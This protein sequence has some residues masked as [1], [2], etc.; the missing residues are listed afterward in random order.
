MLISSGGGGGAVSYSDDIFS[1][2]VYKG[3]GTSLS[4]DNG[5][6]L[7]TY[8]GLVWIKMRDS[9]YQHF[10]CDTRDP[11]VGLSTNNNSAQVSYQTALTSFMSSGF[12][13][14]SSVLVNAA[15]SYI[16]WTFRNANSFFKQLE[17]THMSGTN[18]SINL[19]ALG[20]VGMVAVK[21]TNIVGDWVVW[22]RGATAGNNL[23]LNSNS[24][25]S[26]TNAWLSVV[27]TTATLSSS[28]PSAT[29]VI[30][31]WA[32]DTTSQGN[33]QCG[34]V[35]HAGTTSVS[36][37]WPAQ[38]VLLKSKNTT[39]DWFLIDASRNMSD[40]SYGGHM[41]GNEVGAEE[42]SGNTL[43][44]QTTAGFNINS[45]A[46]SGDYIYIAIRANNRP[47]VVGTDVFHCNAQTLAEGAPIT[48]G[49]QPDM[50]II[51]DNRADTVT[52]FVIDRM[53]GVRTI[54]NGG[55]NKLLTATNGGEA[56]STDRWVW[57]SD[58]YQVSDA[59]NLLSA[60]RWTFRRA[61]GFFSLFTYTGT[62]TNRTTPHDLSVVP[63]LLI[64]KSRSASGDWQVWCNGLAANE[65]LVLNSDA[66]KVTDTTAWNSTPPTSTNITVGTSA[67]TNA[68]GVTYIAYA[69]SNLTGVQKIGTYV[70]DGTSGRV[71]NCGFSA[72]ARF[73]CIKA[74]SAVGGWLISDSTRGIVSGNDPYLQLQGNAA[75]VT[76][77]DWLD[78]SAS[79]FIVNN[80]ATS[81]ANTNGVT[82]LYWAIS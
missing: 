78:P 24:S 21:S 16:A 64:V 26:P 61:P 6:N 77:E 82:Y 63:D 51:K 2:Y 68:N 12:N 38:Y 49:F 40:A 79:G 62:G 44:V 35:S 56:L 80:V 15:A 42:T 37:G 29:Y 55:G 81:N 4:I 70:G 43:C 36:L 14:A 75:E 57:N 32:H 13:L 19:D 11:S 59:Q 39:G 25:E 22:H 33:I 76:T 54:T 10:L 74:V 52:H 5:I 48:T 73:V 1:A 8:G 3:N 28:A 30:Y 31:G 66:A 72:G 34:V 60:V 47:P 18:T 50:Q 53:R 67:N 45:G 58:G 69:F 20:V 17:I 46:L 27:G 41:R 7:S 23:R 65:K 9:A 71:I